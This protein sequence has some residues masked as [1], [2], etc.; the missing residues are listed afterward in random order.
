LLTVPF[1]LSSHTHSYLLIFLKYKNEVFLS[2]QFLMSS[3]L[4]LST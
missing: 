3:Q 1:I 4:I 2:F